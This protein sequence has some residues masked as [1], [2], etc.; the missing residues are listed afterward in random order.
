MCYLCCS[1]TVWYDMVL[2]NESIFLCFHWQHFVDGTCFFFGPT[3]VEDVTSRADARRYCRV[4]T[5]QT[6]HLK[7]MCLVGLVS[8]HQAWAF[9]N[10]VILF[11][12][13]H[14][15][16]SLR[17][18]DNGGRWS[19]QKVV[20]FLSLLTLSPLCSLP[21]SSTLTFYLLCYLVPSFCKCLPVYV[22]AYLCVCGLQ[23]GV[24]DCLISETHRQWQLHPSV[25]RTGLCRE[26][27]LHT[28]K[29]E[30]AVRH[31]YSSIGT[32]TV[33]LP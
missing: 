13:Q 14:E 19:A 11:F 7:L 2:L 18:F 8:V 15:L 20:F 6:A 30:R 26:V 5:L 10:Y 22:H 27:T 32:H 33:A 25:W 9:T 16:E 29:C 23:R 17:L 1:S 3:L 21:I 31:T 12:D 4:K 24:F 28:H